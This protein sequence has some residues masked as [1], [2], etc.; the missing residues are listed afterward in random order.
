MTDIVVIGRGPAGIS[1]ALYALRGGMKVTMVARDGGALLKTKDIENYYGFPEVVSGE[2]LVERSLAQATRLGAELLEDEVVNL[3]Y[4]GTAFTL[5]TT[6]AE[7]AAKAVILAT[8]ASRRQ[9]KIE[10]LA[11]YEGMGVSYCATCD[12]FFY[13]GKDVAVLGNGE[14][15][16]HEAVN[17]L[18]VVNSVT[19]LTN[20]ETPPDD[21]PQELA[22]NTDTIARFEGGET[23]ERVVF[24]N[25]GALAVSGVFVAVGVA[26]SGALARKMGVQTEGHRIVVD[27]DMRTSIPG[28]F[29]AGDCTGG[30]LQIAK[31]VHE[32]AVAGM[33]AVMHVREPALEEYVAEESPDL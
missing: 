15:A 16:V 23:L 2:E 33:A 17:L 28:L 25:G 14:Y 30:M 13:R 32:G 7:L 11:Q 26:G 20:G 3:G 27:A 8:G 5:K 21:M 4:D 1:A 10:G 24:N 9:P 6:R 31:A 29:A 18:P 12:A 22:L 19:L